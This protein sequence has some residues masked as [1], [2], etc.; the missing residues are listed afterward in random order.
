MGMKHKCGCEIENDPVCCRIVE[1]DWDAFHVAILGGD[2]KLIARSPA[3]LSTHQI[4]DFI[5][6]VSQE[7]TVLRGFPGDGR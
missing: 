6:G 2:G 3:R 7:R 5:I 4:P 1:W